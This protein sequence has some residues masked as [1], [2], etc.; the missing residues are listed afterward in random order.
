MAV[1]LPLLLLPQEQDT[2]L[3]EELN[4]KSAHGRKERPKSLLG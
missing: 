1:L 3:G 2:A 4:P